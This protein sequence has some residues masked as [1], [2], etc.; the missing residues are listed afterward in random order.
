MSR[1][2]FKLSQYFLTLLRWTFLGLLTDGVMPKKPPLSK[3][4]H[5]YPTLMK[6]DT[7]I[8]YLKKIQKI[9]K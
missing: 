6:L 8:P 9:Y 3:I 7:V 2:F 5:T 1:N 4:C